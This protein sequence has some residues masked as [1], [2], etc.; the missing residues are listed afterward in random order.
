MLWRKLPDQAAADE[1][2]PAGD[3]SEDLKKNATL[4]EVH[5]QLHFEAAEGEL[6]FFCCSEQRLLL[7]NAQLKIDEPLTYLP[8][9]VWFMT[10]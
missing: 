10:K 8:T 1:A 6:V 4:L 9:F 5:T 3:G 2:E 7:K